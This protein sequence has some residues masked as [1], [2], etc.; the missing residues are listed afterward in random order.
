MTSD[1]ESERNKF[2]R[3]TDKAGVAAR[4]HPC[5]GWG[6]MAKPQPAQSPTKGQGDKVQVFNFD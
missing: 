5:G 2:F 1:I 3:D 6:T 4:V